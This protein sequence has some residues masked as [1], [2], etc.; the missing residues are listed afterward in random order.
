M[1]HKSFLFPFKTHKKFYDVH[2]TF[3]TQFKPLAYVFMIRQPNI[4][5]QNFACLSQRS[6]FSN[7]QLNEYDLSAYSTPILKRCY[8]IVLIPN[9]FKSTTLLCGADSSLQNIC[10]NVTNILHNTF[11]DLNNVMFSNFTTLFN[12]KWTTLVVVWG[13]A[14]GFE[15]W[16]LLPWSAY[17]QPPYNVEWVPNTMYRIHTFEKGF[18]CTTNAHDDVGVKHTYLKCVDVKLAK[19]NITCFRIQILTPILPPNLHTCQY[20]TKHDI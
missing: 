4:K 15:G 3:Q 5:L 12:T 18:K 6:Q 1:L 13:R 17:P 20:Y 10:L 19:Y 9:I 7:D 2:H 16:I 8:T 14:W 11:T